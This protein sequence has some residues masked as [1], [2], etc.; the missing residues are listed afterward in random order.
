M[1]GL[2]RRRLLSLGIG[3]VALVLAAAPLPG[4]RRPL[5]VSVGSELEASLRRL[6][7]AFERQ[8]GAIDLRWQV[9]GSQDM[10]NN[11]LEPGPERPRVLIPAN[12]ELLEQFEAR[13]TAMGHGQPFTGRPTPIART[14]L[15][16]VIWPERAQ[17]LFPDGRFSWTRLRAAVAAGQWGGLGAPAAW[18]SFDLRAT[19]PLR[20]NSGQLLLALWS[21]GRNDA[22]AVQSLRRAIYRPARSTDILLREFISGGPNEGDLAFVY[23]A[24]AVERAPEAAQRWP[25]GY[26]VL[27]PDPTMEVVSAAAVLRGPATGGQADG[28][29]LVAF[30]TGPRG[31]ELLRAA[32][33]RPASGQGGGPE[34]QRGR[35]LPP[36]SESERE[37]LQRQWQR[38]GD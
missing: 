20:S 15:V 29:R 18:G 36:P 37:E 35:L 1:S 24:G 12:L 6:E 28:E 25:G 8:E 31:Q 14:R 21:L 23:E 9:E 19:D 30:L 32:G 3:V 38:A 16:A 17:R 26:K 11:H 2:T 27:V 10:V 5:L 33:Y 13:S 22:T 7:P 4:L 34:G